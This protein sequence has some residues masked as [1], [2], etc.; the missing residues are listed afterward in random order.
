MTARVLI[1]DDDEVTRRLLNEILEKQGYRIDLAESGEEALRRMSQSPP[2]ACV[3]SDIRM[4]NLDG[5]AVLREVKKRHPETSVLLMTGFGSMQGAVEAIREGAFDYVS[6]P[7]QI[8]E[9]KAMV[10]RAVEQFKLMQTRGKDALP[11]TLSTQKTLIGKSPKMIDV[12]KTIARAALSSSTVLIQGE[13]GTGKELA[14]KAI[15]D[16][17]P[18]NQHRFI[19]INCGALSESLL[20]SELFGHKKGSFTGA[21]SD[22]KGLFEEAEGGTVFLDEIGDISPALQ[23]KL[24]RVL[25][26]GEVRRV[27]ESLPRKVDVRIIAA[28]HQDLEELVRQQ[29]FREDLYYRLKVISIYL[30]PLRERMEDLDELVELFLTRFSR[31][32]SPASRGPGRGSQVSP[33]ALEALRHYHWP[34]NIR[35]L[36]NALERAV[37][38]SNSTVLHP[39]DFSEEIRLA[40]EKGEGRASEVH[41]VSSTS[42]LETIEKKHILTVLKEV[43]FNKSRAS[44]RLGIDRATL[45]RKAQKYGID[46]KGK[47]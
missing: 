7:F 37:A 6:K 44:E 11:S 27:G 17:S 22:H 12:Y 32:Q 5:F 18:R 28:T 40:R 30:P 4:L 29:E 16:N 47:G 19:A 20:E 25:Q 13:S 42:S 34:G 14:A 43:G 2:Y 23:V 1:V 41:G 3:L 36:E 46:L 33:A 31:P 9:L 45:Y 10:V 38:L 15:H 8:Q 21:L 24:L 35:E 39:E 26:E